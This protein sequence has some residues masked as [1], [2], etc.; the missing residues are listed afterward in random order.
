MAANMESIIKELVKN[1]KKETKGHTYQNEIFDLVKTNGMCNPGHS[2]SKYS[3][4]PDF[5]LLY[6]HAEVKLGPHA[7]YHQRGILYDRLLSR[8][9]LNPVVLL[10]PKTKDWFDRHPELL[11]FINDTWRAPCK[12]DGDKSTLNYLM[13]CKVNCPHQEKLD[14]SAE[15]LFELVCLHYHFDKR[16]P[17]IQIGEGQG[18]YH[19]VEDFSHL[20][21]SKL[22]ASPGTAHMSARVKLGA[23]DKKKKS[24]AKKNEKK[25]KKVVQLYD[26][27]GFPIDSKGKRIKIVPADYTF[28]FE[29][30]F[31]KGFA[32]SKIDLSN[33]EDMARLVRDHR[34]SFQ[35]NEI[36]NDPRFYEWLREGW[37]T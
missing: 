13:D 6:W 29:V 19:F 18:L 15:D 25:G 28:Q 20:G 16:R 4:A 27:E 23:S 32:K 11:E 24:D 17:Y 30:H 21:T 10:R 26:S 8:W 5:I 36:K 35:R 22:I 7:F 2:E 9:V 37:F 3:E 31:K 33:P 1:R 12:V 14:V 34:E